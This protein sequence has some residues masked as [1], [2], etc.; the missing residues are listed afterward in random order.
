MA[1]RTPATLWAARLSNTRC[2]P[3]AARV[4]ASA[5]D[6][7]AISP[8]PAAMPRGW[9]ANEADRPIDGAALTRGRTCTPATAR[10]LARLGRR[11]AAIGSRDLPAIM[12]CH[13][14]AEAL[15]TGSPVVEVEAS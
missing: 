3:A 5:R 11:P 2:R 15:R 13:L 9:R 8:S 14:N 12:L 10:Q 7:Q 1:S 6:Q 4:P